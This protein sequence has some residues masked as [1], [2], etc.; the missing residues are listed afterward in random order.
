MLSLPAR[1][2]RVAI[3]GAGA[4]GAEFASM[5]TSFGSKVVLIELLPRVLPLED[6]EVSETVLR[7]FRKRGIEVLTNT[8]V[9][10]AL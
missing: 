4:V 3:V 6:E 7:S 1:P 2:E 5:F 10:S 9:E 8:R